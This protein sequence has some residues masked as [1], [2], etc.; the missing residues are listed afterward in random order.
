MAQPAVLRRPPLGE[1]PAGAYDMAREFRILSRLP[2]ALPFVPR[3]L[4]LC[5][6][7]SVIGAAVPDHRIPAGPGD[8]R[9]HAARAGRPAGGRRAAVAGA[10]G[11]A[12]RRSMRSTPRR[13]GWTTSAGRRVSWRARSAAGAS[14]GWRRWR[15]GT[16][17][18]HAELG[19]WLERHLVPDGP[20]GAAA[21]RLQAEQH[22]PRPARPVAGRGGGL[23]PGHARRSAVRFRHA[24]ELL[25]ARG[26]SAGDAR[27]GAD[28]GGRRRLLSRASRRWRPMP[29]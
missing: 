4:F 15:T 23:G 1:L 25:G 16:E 26:R 6:D 18:L 13:S 5:A 17:T 7:P 20:P 28:A 12:W 14:A 29:R 27:H 10:A 8:P 11:D 24:A 21:Q 22:D 19:T 2:D 3:G 9:A